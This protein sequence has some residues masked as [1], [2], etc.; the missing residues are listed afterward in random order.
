MPVCRCYAVASLWR[1][2]RPF[3]RFPSNAARA[4]IASNAQSSRLNGSVRGGRAGL[5]SGRRV[6]KD[7]QDR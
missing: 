3:L 1:T 2:T 7:V 6:P 5:R 4:E